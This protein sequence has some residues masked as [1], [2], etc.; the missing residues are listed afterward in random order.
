MVSNQSIFSQQFYSPIFQNVEYDNSQAVPGK[1][2]CSVDEQHCRAME[3]FLK[4]TRNYSLKERY[5][6]RFRIHK[7]PP[8]L[9]K[10]LHFE[11]KSKYFICVFVLFFV[12]QDSGILN[13]KCIN[14]LCSQQHSYLQHDL[15]DSCYFRLLRVKVKANKD[16]LV[17][18]LNQ[19]NL[20]L[21]IFTPKY[22]Y[23][24]SSLLVLFHYN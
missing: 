24:M 8:A 9:K 6:H 5:S 23:F 13:S 22:E 11:T 4:K 12:S 3:A 10:S 20:A 14:R 7:P 16:S 1:P 21:Y 2:I 18:R 15:L 19:L 17:L